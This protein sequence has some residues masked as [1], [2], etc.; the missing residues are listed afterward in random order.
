MKE[1]TCD[2]RTSWFQLYF[3]LRMRV[4]ERSQL[5]R[6]VPPARRPKYASQAFDVRSAGVLFV[7]VGSSAK[8]LPRIFNELVTFAHEE[9]VRV[10]H[11]LIVHGWHG[12]SPQIAL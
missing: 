8:V 4:T 6:I 3:F 10:T 2:L 1:M 12:S 7:K 9:V 5:T 11:R